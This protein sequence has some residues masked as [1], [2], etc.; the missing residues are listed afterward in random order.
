MI[1]KSIKCIV[2]LFLLSVTSLFSQT[3][4]LVNKSPIITDSLT[5]VKPIP[6]AQLKEVK[7]DTSKYHFV[8]KKSPMGAVWRSLILPGWGQIYTENY[9]KSPMF[10]GAAGVLV[11][12]IW[13]N[14]NK[15]VDKSYEVKNM[16]RNSPDN[17]NLEILISQRETYRDNRDR[18]G[19]LLLGVYVLSAVDAF[20]D[21]HLFDFDVSDKVNLSLFPDFYTYPKVS[22]QIHIK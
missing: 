8:M 3:D 2:F 14:H 16:K 18:N 22:M 10:M 12:F 6:A 21:A 15:F 17:P 7:G 4:T 9:W 20:V 11:Y 5:A 19:L 13:D 1:I